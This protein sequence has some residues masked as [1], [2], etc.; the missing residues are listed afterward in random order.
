MVA[1][2]GDDICVDGGGIGGGDVGDDVVDARG[3]LS[4]GD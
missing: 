1:G 3:R 4:G 2:D